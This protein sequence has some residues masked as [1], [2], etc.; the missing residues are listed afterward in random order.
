MFR[1]LDR[2]RRQALAWYFHGQEVNR[3][4]ATQPQLNPSATRSRCT[5][6]LPNAISMAISRLK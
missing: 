6:V 5:S 2:M 4:H 3:L 1:R